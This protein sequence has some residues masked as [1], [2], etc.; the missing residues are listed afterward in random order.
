MG[1]GPLL[2]LVSALSRQH[3]GIVHE[4]IE[5]VSD[6]SVYQMGAGSCCAAVVD[7]T[8]EIITCL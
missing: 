3:G 6:K 7:A 2:D 4:V 5:E 1:P 8:H